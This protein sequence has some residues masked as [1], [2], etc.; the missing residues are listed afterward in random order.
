MIVGET[1]ELQCMAFGVPAPSTSWETQGTVLRSGECINITERVL[2]GN[3]SI[4]TLTISNVALSDEG[5]FTCVADNGVGPAVNSTV[6]LRILCKSPY[7]PTIIVYSQVLPFTV[8]PEIS[9]PFD[10]VEVVIGSNIT[11]TCSASGFHRPDFNWIILEHSERRL[12]VM[13]N[14]V[15]ETYVTSQVEFL[16]TTQTDTGNYSCIAGN[17]VG[18]ATEF[19]F[20]QV[21]GILI[22][23]FPY[24][25]M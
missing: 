5:Q 9:T 7:T 24:C 12:N 17:N 23:N 4:S 21:L 16:N 25:Y 6:I 1:A 2:T 15:N 13:T 19:I 8:L 20:L 14:I 3:I 22:G 11:L 10:N 18:E